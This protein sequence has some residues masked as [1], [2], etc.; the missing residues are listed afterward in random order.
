[1]ALHE[2]QWAFVS[3]LVIVAIK[4]IY[5]VLTFT[6]VKEMLQIILVWEVVLLL[7]LEGVG[8]IWL[9]VLSVLADFEDDSARGAKGKFHH[10]SHHVAF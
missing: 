1:M 10:A 6:F 3:C 5:L 7:V 2:H 9:L 4:F 8:V